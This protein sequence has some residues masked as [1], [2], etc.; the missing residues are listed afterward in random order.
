MQ[1][2]MSR[3]DNKNVGVKNQKWL[4]SLLSYNNFFKKQSETV[5]LKKIVLLRSSVHHIEIAADEYWS[6]MIQITNLVFISISWKTSLFPEKTKSLVVKASKKNLLLRAL[7]KLRSQVFEV[8]I[9]LNFLSSRLKLLLFQ[10]TAKPVPNF[11]TF[12]VPSN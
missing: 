8:K 10:K 12:Y 2:T 3:L 4:C 5:F 6:C 9:T 11:C 7:E 1:T